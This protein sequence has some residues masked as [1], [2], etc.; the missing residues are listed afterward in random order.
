MVF[1]TVQQHQSWYPSRQRAQRLKPYLPSTLARTHRGP[2]PLMVAGFG[3][4][5]ATSA[6][7]LVSE[8][9]A[10]ICLHST[11]EGDGKVSQL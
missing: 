6:A 11:H 5:I 4:A 9:L 7:K 10:I 2:M 3:P 8:R 1:V